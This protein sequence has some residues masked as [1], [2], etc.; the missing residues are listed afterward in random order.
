MHP[1]REKRLIN[2]FYAAQRVP[3]VMVSLRID[4][5]L[6]VAPYLTKEQAAAVLTANAAVLAHIMLM[7]GTEAAKKLAEG[8][9]HEN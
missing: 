4:D 2:P 6:S 3:V 7:A 1:E 8:I 5:V 9:D